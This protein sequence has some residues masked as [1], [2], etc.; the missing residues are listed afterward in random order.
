MHAQHAEQGYTEF[1]TYA[2][3]V[4]I[5]NAARD[6][7]RLDTDA[8]FELQRLSCFF[9]VDDGPQTENTRLLPQVSI[10]LLDTGTGRTVFGGYVLTSELFGDGR[11]PFILPTTHFFKRGA[12]V[13]V[14]YDPIDPGPDFDNGE[15]WLLL[16]G[17]KHY[18]Y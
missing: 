2:L 7:I 16:I 1:F 17:R 5:P 12:Q 8:D 6:V 15:L 4:V 3:R 18:E 10:N 13:Q 9:T 14:Q 11:V